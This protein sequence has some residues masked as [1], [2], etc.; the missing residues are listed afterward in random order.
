M[1]TN[2]KN[3][4]HVS[5]SIALSLLL[6]ASF[7]AMAQETRDGSG[8]REDYFND[9][10]M[11]DERIDSKEFE[12]V[13]STA[14]YLDEWDLNDD[15]AFDDSEFNVVLYTVWDRD[16]DSQISQEEWETGT[17]N[18]IDEYDTEAY[19]QYEDWD[20]NK[21]QKVDINEF[22]TAI[23]KTNKFNEN[24]ADKMEKM[25]KEELTDAVFKIWDT[26]NDEYIEK[27]EFG[28]WTKRLDKDDN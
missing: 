2:I 27:I 24:K 1:K 13:L 16:N 6:I 21:D 28:N 5:F 26:D 11:N 19:G 15:D 4:I 18:Y 8:N 25:S 3:F 9:T 12:E 23:G 17:Q 14:G 20:T 22:G 10:D 7:N